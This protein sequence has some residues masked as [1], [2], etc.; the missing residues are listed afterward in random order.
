M[1]M[2]IQ[3]SNFPMLI[4]FLL[5]VAIALKLWKK[6][7]IQYK[8]PP[9]P[10]KLPL[11]GNLHQLSSSLPHHTFKNLSNKYGPMMHLQLG[12]V[13]AVIVSSPQVAKEVLKTHDLIFANRPQLLSVQILS[14]NCP[15]L[16]FSPYGA[17]WRQLRKVCVL[18]LLSAKRVQSFESI[19]EEEVE[20]LIEAISLIH[21][22]VPIDISEMIFSMMNNITARAAFGKK[23]K[24]KDEFI[25][26]M[27]TITEL[28]GGF[29][30]PDLFPSLKIFHS[31]S[32]VRSA[33]E[34]VHQNVDK[35]F[36]DI[37]QEHKANK[38]DM[39]YKEDLVDVLLR[40][41]ES[42]DLEIPL[43]RNTL[44]SVIL[45][46][47]IGGTD[48]SSTVLEWAISEMMKNPQVMEKAQ[49]EVRQVFKGKSKITESEIQKLDY[50]KLVIKETLRMHPPVP[51]L[52]PREAIEK[53]DI[54]GYEIPAKTKV[55]INAWAIGRHPEHWKNAECFEPERF[56]D[57]DLDFFGTNLEYI[58]FGG[59]RRI[60]P[61][62]LFGI[63]NVEL[64]LAKL[65]FHFDW[66]LPDGIEAS[67]LDMT[68]TFGATV[69]RKNDLYLVAKPY[70]SKSQD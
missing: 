55:I 37:I 1:I 11:I 48:T 69:G 20:N 39:L 21:P 63:A 8:L 25:K 3:H 41:Q 56:Q 24:H 62:I 19:R 12:E 51:L 64:P 17:N 59:G 58:P 7:K 29:D 44:K 50:M 38:R 23:C 45:E 5:F 31:L 18:E 43:S 22:Q 57:S 34:K 42:G 54:G 13:S 6:S 40:V 15:T 2:E 68:E 27:K 14:N 28:S 10:R 49:A 35:I 46:M 9:G 32:G 33:L 47:F 26:A 36:E 61:G 70:I 30:I 66:K 60:C 52:L 65:L 16:S 53:C 67:D 4:A